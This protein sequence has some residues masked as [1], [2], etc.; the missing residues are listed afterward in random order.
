MPREFHI[1]G[2]AATLLGISLL[3]VV[4]IDL[5]DFASKS[6][7]DEIALVA[8]GLLAT[9]SILSFLAIRRANKGERLETVADQIFICGLL[10]LVLAVAVLA[11]STGVN[12]S[13]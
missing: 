5:T 2:V 10:T 13:P 12:L 8:S 1:L 6:I 11:I 4:G 9:S 7:A 3:V